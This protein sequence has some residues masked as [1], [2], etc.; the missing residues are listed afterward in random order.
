MKTVILFNMDKRRAVF[1]YQRKGL[2]FRHLQRKLEGLSK[3][4]PKEINYSILSNYNCNYLP[5]SAL[6]CFYSSDYLYFLMHCIR[7]LSLLKEATCYLF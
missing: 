3:L 2:F 7:I 6:I 4:S 1:L 5:P